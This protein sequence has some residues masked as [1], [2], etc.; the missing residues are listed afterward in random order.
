MARAVVALVVLVALAGCGSSGETPAGAPGTVSSQPPASTAAP[1]PNPSLPT[2]PR[3]GDCVASTE[4]VTVRPAEPPLR[5]CVVVGA[6]LRVTSAPSKPPWQSLSTSDPSVVSCRSQS[7]AA[8]VLD[9]AC[10]AERP[11]T[12][13]LSTTTGHPTEARPD[14]VWH[15]TVTVVA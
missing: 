4:E 13:V 2:L 8:G 7:G 1:L 15:L 6:T 14:T 3:R 11:G 12:A 5:T 9:G 10:R